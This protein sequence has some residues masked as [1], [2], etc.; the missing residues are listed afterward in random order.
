MADPHDRFIAKVMNR[1][2]P[3]VEGVLADR[4]WLLDG[5]LQKSVLVPRKM[6]DNLLS[7][8]LGGRH[9][10]SEVESSPSAPVDNAEAVGALR[11]AQR[12]LSKAGSMRVNACLTGV[13]SFRRFDAERPTSKSGTPARDQ[14]S[15]RQQGLLVGSC[16]QKP[17]GLRVLVS[18]CRL[19]KL[20]EVIFLCS[21]RGAARR[22]EADRG[23]Q[24]R[25]PH[26]V[27]EIGIGFHGRKGWSIHCLDEPHSEP[28]HGK[29][30]SR[31]RSVSADG[32]HPG[33]NAF[34]P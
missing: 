2:Y 11:K 3:S 24:G 26:F 1:G 14:R 21:S 30:A 31:K 19:Q 6:A 25:L 8:I 33:F 28:R 13:E 23:S 12:W 34:V 18:Y 4:R 20:A 5:S 32:R 16:A 9:G 27:T 15:I 29:S 17:S 7:E 10:T 22:T